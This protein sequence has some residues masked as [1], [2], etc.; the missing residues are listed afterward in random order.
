MSTSK[1]KGMTKP[2]ATTPK[3]DRG[4]TVSDVF[5][6][7]RE[8]DDAGSRESQQVAFQERIVKQLLRRANIQLQVAATKREAF[9]QRGSD[10]LDFRWFNENYPRFPLH[11]LAQK[12]RYTHTAT[13]GELYG[14]GQ[15]KRLPWWKEYESQVALYDINLQNERAALIFN[16]PLAKDAFLMVLHN[17]PIQCEMIED[18]ERRKDQP[19]PRTTFPMG[20]SGVVAVLEAFDSFLQTVGT[21]WAAQ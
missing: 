9:D 3:S 7:M 12:M 13:L 17:Q 11:L 4:F 18:A 6:S 10:K 8:A 5:D 14:Q 2:K 21:E 16:L 1:A 19:W 20:K 15:F